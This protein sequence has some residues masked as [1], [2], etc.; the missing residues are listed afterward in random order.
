MSFLSLDTILARIGNKGTDR[1]HLAVTTSELRDFFISLQ[2]P[3]CS[4]SLQ[5]TATTNTATTPGEYVKIEGLTSANSAGYLTTSLV[6]NRMTYVGDTPRHFHVA[7]SLSF[8]KTGGGAADDLAFALAVNGVP[9]LETEVTRRTSQNQIGSTA[10]HG[11]FMLSKGDY[12]ELWGTN[13]D[14]GSDDIITENLY[15]FMVGMLM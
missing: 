3:W 5:S 4:I 2:P 7:V 12:V 13:K 8:S 15:M 9:K 10:I 6:D 1:V 14:A 11:D